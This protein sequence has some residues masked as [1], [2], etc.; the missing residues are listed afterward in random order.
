VDLLQGDHATEAVLRSDDV[1][2][3]LELINVIRL[4]KRAARVR[5]ENVVEARHRVEEGRHVLAIRRSHSNQLL[6]M[7]NVRAEN[8]KSLIIKEVEKKL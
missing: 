3:L 5:G 8:N 7:N 4:E 2:D 6:I 1:S